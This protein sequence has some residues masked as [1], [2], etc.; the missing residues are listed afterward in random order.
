MATGSQVRSGRAGQYVGVT[1]VPRGMEHVGPRFHRDTQNSVQFKTY[2]LVIS[3][4]SHL[5]F[6]DRGG[7]WA[8]EAVEGETRGEEGDR[9]VG[10]NFNNCA[11]ACQGLVGWILP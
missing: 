2:K 1:R 8:A 10:G 9:C 11:A 6:L 7:P 5:V 4:T 3:W